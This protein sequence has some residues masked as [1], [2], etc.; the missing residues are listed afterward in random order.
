MLR[1]P[2]RRRPSDSGR[3]TR[4]VLAAAAL[5]LAGFAGW[6]TAIVPHARDEVELG[7]A[8]ITLALVSA[9]LLAA[10][11]GVGAARLAPARRLPA[12]LVGVLVLGGGMLS[13]TV[14]V[15]VPGLLT[16]FAPVATGLGLVVVA[17][18]TLVPRRAALVL[19][20]AVPAGALLALVAGDP[21][22]VFALGGA[23]A[24]AAAVPLVRAGAA[25]PALVRAVAGR[26]ARFAGATGLLLAVAGLIQ[27]TALLE[28][29]KA[30]FEALHG[31][32][33]TPEVIE[34][35]LVEPSLR[36]YVIIVIVA[37]L[38]GARYWGRT[39]PVRTLL[40]VAGAGI[41]AYAGV[42]TCWALWER[43][44][45]EEVLGIDP[46]NGHSWAAYP[47]FPSGH[48]AVTTA[49]AFAT[50]ALIPKLRYVL[51]GYAVVI[52]FTRLAYGAHFP[53]DVLLGFVLGWLAVR[54][55]ITPLPVVS[56]RS[57]DPLGGFARAAPSMGAHPIH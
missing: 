5:A 4:P 36:N 57:Q 47:S 39:T 28:L 2:G 41:V 42:L 43:P 38:V 51:W 22:T 3:R 46:G 34:S 19:P 29:D 23:A 18:A 55:A 21:R 40:L 33:A 32:G 16:S 45:P 9:A 30:V 10:A 26:A 20:A 50:A 53:S 13:S 54:T 44:R 56:E 6:A 49:L 52:A 27:S 12:L 8:A 11:A 1:R 7:T 25:P 14:G 31:L 35:L 17:A 15:T 37:S 24:L 48:V